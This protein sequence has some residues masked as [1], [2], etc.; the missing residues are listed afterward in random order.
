MII[1]LY[2]AALSAI[3]MGNDQ[4]KVKTWMNIRK[5]NEYLIVENR[6]IQDY[7]CRLAQGD[8]SEGVFSTG[9]IHYE[10]SMNGNRIYLSVKGSYEE[11]L[12][13]YYDEESGF[14]MDY[15]ASRNVKAEE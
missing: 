3:I 15:D 2:L 9:D 6:V 1:L 13:L 4:K 7:R 11:E 12:I 14:I 5:A 8:C 10:A